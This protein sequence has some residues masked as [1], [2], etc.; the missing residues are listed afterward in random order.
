MQSERGV[1]MVS[2]ADLGNIRTLFLKGTRDILM[3][4]A[5]IAVSFSETRSLPFILGTQDSPPLLVGVS[6]EYKRNGS[7]NWSK[8]KDLHHCRGVN[9]KT[10]QHSRF[11]P[12]FH[13]FG[14]RNE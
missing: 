8:Q 13:R 2:T 6:V 9:K 11:L 5:I 7:S 10:L 12:Q 14:N 1:I 3:V 4:Q